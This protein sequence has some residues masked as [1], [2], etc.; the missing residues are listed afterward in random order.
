[1]R[2]FASPFWLVA[3]FVLPFFGCSEKKS[4]LPS[5]AWPPKTA[6]SFRLDS[7]L[8]EAVFLD[9]MLGAIVGSAIGDA[10][11]GPTEMWHRDYIEA[12]FGYID[13][14]EGMIRDGTPEGP[15]ED[16]LPGG[17]TTD[18]TRWK[19]IAAQF[20]IEKGAKKD[21]LDPHDFARFLL[22]AYRT[23]MEKA[24]KSPVFPPEAIEKEL[25]RVAWLQEWAKVAHAYESGDADKYAYTLDRFYGGEMACAGMLYAPIVGAFF[26]AAPEKAYLEAYRIGLFDHGFA[27]D[28]TG[29]TAAMV[30]AAMK[31]NMNFSRL[32]YE[33]S[34]GVDPLR[35]FNSRL[36]GRIAFRIWADARYIV[37]QSKKLTEKDIP[38]DQKTPKGWP[39][40]R[41]EWAQTRKAYEL[42]DPKL[43]DIPFHA[44]E[45]HFINLVALQFGEG[46]FQKTIDFV[47]NFGRDNDTVGAVTGA[48]L[49]GFLGFEKLPKAWREQVL[50]TNKN[51][52]GIDLEDLAKKLVAARGR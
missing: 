31:P 42:M 6:S 38:A 51:V 33:V 30:S 25:M 17:S 34:A 15:W 28:I 13:T 20:L 23:D 24:K 37:S 32:T 1:M 11:G 16:N 47:T 29:L 48:V 40:S 14:L 7:S 3:L 2:L 39:G 12:Q 49:G 35:F 18:D 9:K 8:T 45:I 26:P 27:R 36:S 19:A 21:S 52:V 44:A 4:N 22:E 5:P 46:D 50:R 10:H 41:L 43:Q